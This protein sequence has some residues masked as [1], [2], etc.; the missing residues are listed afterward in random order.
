MLRHVDLIGQKF[1]RLTVV[2]FAY[3]KNKRAYWE[4]ECDCKKDTSNELNHVI[5]STKSL[6]NGS[7]QSCGC[8]KVEKLK[9][10]NKVDYP[11]WFIDELAN[12]SEKE[13]ARNG[14]LKS[15][16]KI[17]FVCPIHGVYNQKVG[18]HI[19]NGKRKHGCPKCSIKYKDLVGQRFGELMVIK[20]NEKRNKNGKITW[21]CKCDCGN[22]CDVITHDLISGK[23]LHCK[24]KEKHKRKSK[25]FIDL[26][27]QVFNILAIKNH[28]GNNSKRGTKLKDDLRGKKVGRLTVIS[29]NKDYTWDCVCEC[30]NHINVKTVKLTHGS[31][32]MCDECKAK[33][34]EK[35]ENKYIGMQFNN[36]TVLNKVDSDTYRCKCNCGTIRNVSLKNLK[37]GMSK[38]CGKCSR[39]NPNENLVGHK[40][41]HLTVVKYVGDGRWE[42]ECDCEKPLKE[43]I[44]VT[45]TALKNGHVK[46][47]GHLIHESKESYTSIDVTGVRSGLL[48]AIRPTD[49]RNS[50]C[51]VYWECKC[52]CG[53]TSYVTA[54]NIKLGLVRACSNHTIA[55]GGSQAEKDIKYYI[56]QKG[57]NAVK[58]R[59]ILN[60]KEID[61]YIPDLKLGIEYNG[62]VFH[63][64]LNGVYEDKYKYYHRDKF[65]LAKEKGVHLIS[66][67]DVDWDNNQDKIKMYLS[68][69]LIKPNKLYARKCKLEKVDDDISVG[70]VDKYHL[71]G[72]NK[73]TMKIN[74]G[75]YYENKLMAIMSFGRL[76][77]AKHKEGH[78]EL[79]RYC[80]KDGYTILGGA[81]RLLRA[82]ER[83]YKPKYLV[84]YS[85]NDYFLGGIYERLKFENVGQSFPRYYWYLNGIELKREKCRL[86]HLK[87]DYPELLQEAYDNNAKNKEDYVMCALGACKVYRSGNTKWEKRY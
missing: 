87:E 66:I 70:F 83:E 65:L 34:K 75:L 60:G 24:D 77:L 64:T 50:K 45:T 25:D 73:A 69:L 10:I 47:C 53:S 13:R 54:T 81:E 38:S 52:D 78:Y 56:G 67:F 82:F 12:E 19:S 46:S 41:N 29:Q 76:R 23:R 72:A 57:F 32:S 4:C 16:D 61:I 63:A 36:W 7:T 51:Q 33:Q 28:I 31:I 17:D 68:S 42:C 30:G 37:S 35:E 40:F 11:Q 44:I 80:V 74:Y 15:T 3:T 22:E 62:S 86:K 14:E 43:K 18:E 71:Q 39:S 6:R 26:T 48:V 59:N 20:Q 85:D 21:H 2:K 5:V 9:E 84:S 55:H 8:L 1:G 27:G 49:R 79:H 58:D